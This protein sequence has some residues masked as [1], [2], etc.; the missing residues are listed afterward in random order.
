MS[1]GERP[2]A[3]DY[4]REKVKGHFAIYVALIEAIALIISALI[5]YY[6]NINAQK[7][8]AA[9]QQQNNES[10]ATISD[11]KQENTALQEEKSDTSAVQDENASLQE[12]ITELEQEKSSL[13]AEITALRETN[14]SLETNYNAALAQLSAMGETLQP[15]DESGS[16]S[17]NT[18]AA[19]AGSKPD[20]WLDDLDYFD[21]SSYWETGGVTKDNAGY[22]H[23]HSINRTWDGFWSYTRENGYRIYV[24][25]GKYTRMT[26]S[27]YQEYDYRSSGGNTTL[28]MYNEEEELLWQGTVARAIDPIPFDV[29]I[30]G[31][32]KLKIELSGSNASYTALGEVGL[33]S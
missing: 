6:G 33:W 1:K 26:G 22:D 14:S 19:K 8:I 25:D 29:D 16:T 30:T 2:I 21:E 4:T 32:I 23:A 24:L 3:D 11:L 18:R 9:L 5:G 31:V 20:T 10:Q 28:S 17:Q 15:S 13:Q 12:R 7:A 27:F